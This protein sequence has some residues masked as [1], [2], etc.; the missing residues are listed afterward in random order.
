MDVRPAT[1]D[2]IKA[3]VAVLAALPDYFTPNTHD[4]ARQ[5][6][7]RDQAWVATDAG[8]VIGFLN[9]QS[10]YRRTAEIMFAAVVRDRQGAGVGSALV[11]RALDELAAAGVEL[12]EVKTLDGSAG[13][14]PY[15]A[16][17]AFWERWGFRQIDC[18][19]PLPGWPAGNPAAIYVRSI[20]GG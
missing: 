20:A 16:T 7:A 17:R 11:G 12:V 4:E 18:I 15:V 19:D 8:Q 9:A 2:D 1:Q 3:C 5:E 13:Y 6:L 10:R 14:E